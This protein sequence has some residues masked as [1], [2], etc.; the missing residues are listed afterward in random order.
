MAIPDRL[1]GDEFWDKP[2]S[3]EELI[4][5][6]AS[7]Q[8]SIK[9]AL[10]LTPWEVLEAGLGFIGTD[11]TLILAPGTNEGPRRQMLEDNSSTI[12][13]R[14]STVLQ[15]Q[16]SGMPLTVTAAGDAADGNAWIPIIPNAVA[17]DGAGL[18]A[19][20]EL[21][22][23]SA[24]DR[25]DVMLWMTVDTIF[26]ANQYQFDF[27]TDPLGA[28]TGPNATNPAWVAVEIPLL[29]GQTTPGNTWG[30][31][32]FTTVDAEGFGIADG[33]NGDWPNNAQVSFY[34]F[35]RYI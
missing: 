35:Y 8:S 27:R 7:L 4:A 23:P 10:E 19:A 14:L 28:G 34:G 6:N 31:R 20:A 21:V 26:G 17:A 1:K 29:A 11:G 5:V 9:R 32:F 25:I 30:H 13:S 18:P 15:R 24:G 12:S 3:M 2:V 22:A 16:I 33:A